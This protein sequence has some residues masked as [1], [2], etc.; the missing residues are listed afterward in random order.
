MVDKLLNFLYTEY[1]TKKGH[2]SDGCE[3]GMPSGHTIMRKKTMRGKEEIPS[4]HTIMR[5]KTMRSKEEIPSGHTIMRK[6]QCAVRRKREK[7]KLDY[8]DGPSGV[9]HRQR[10]AGPDFADISFSSE[11][12]QA[13]P[14]GKCVGS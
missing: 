5:K 10:A 2:L 3:G 4:G 8:A 14:D 7:Q 11:S 12:A 6:K 1:M 9:L 13:D